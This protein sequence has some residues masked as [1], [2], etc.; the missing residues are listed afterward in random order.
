MRSEVTARER[1]EQERQEW[2]AKQ[3]RADE[4][5]EEPT[6]LGPKPPKQS[7]V[8]PSD[9]SAAGFHQALA[10]RHGRAVVFGTEIDRLVNALS[11]EW[12]KIDAALREAYEHEALSYLRKT[13]ETRIC[14]PKLS[15]VLSGTP[16]QFRELIPSTENG[17]FSRMALYYFEAP[18]QWIDQ[19]PTRKGRKKPERFEQLA[20]K[21]KDLYLK[22]GRREEPLWFEMEERHWDQHADTF[23]PM[24]RWLYTCGA[25]HLESVIRRAGVTAFRAAMTLCVLRAFERGDQ[26]EAAHKLKAGDADVDAGLMLAC[27]WADHALRFA[28]TLPHQPSPDERTGR[29]VRLLDCLPA[30]FSNEEVYAVADDMDLDVS[31][32]TLRRDLDK[33][34]RKGLIQSPKKSH[35]R[36][37]G[38]SA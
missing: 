37:V 29:V 8:L 16:A 4:E 23:A 18:G 19:R 32:R 7:L 36:Q 2:E 10:A 34:E 14:D 12:G 13:E 1:S 30:A 35:W 5:D 20:E 17:L 28:R 26:L 11:Q 25:G 24:R 33:A 22:L 6:A 31:R 21:V 9:M 38:S 3:E 15:L 27:T